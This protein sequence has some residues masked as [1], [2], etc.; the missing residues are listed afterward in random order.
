MSDNPLKVGVQESGEP[1]EVAVSRGVTGVDDGSDLLSH[2]NFTVGFVSIDQH[3][4]D[5]VCGKKQTVGLQQRLIFLLI[6][7]LRGH[8]VR[9]E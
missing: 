1:L 2:T 4:F 7:A 8:G 5:Q 6:T 9:G 3:F